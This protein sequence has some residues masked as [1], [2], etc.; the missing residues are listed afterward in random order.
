MAW[1]VPDHKEQVAVGGVQQCTGTGCIGRTS[2]NMPYGEGNGFRGTFSTR[3][4]PLSA[5]P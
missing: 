4:V 2:E 5:E 3:A 1:I